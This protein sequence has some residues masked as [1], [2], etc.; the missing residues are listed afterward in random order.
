MTQEQKT[1][2]LKKVK[3]LTPEQEMALAPKLKEALEAEGFVEG[4]LGTKRSIVQDLSQVRV[5]SPRGAKGTKAEGFDNDFGRDN[6]GTVATGSYLDSPNPWG[7]EGTDKPWATED[8]DVTKGMGQELR[9]F[10]RDPTKLSEGQRSFF[11]IETAVLA[12]AQAAEA[13]AA[14]AAIAIK[15]PTTS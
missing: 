14:L 9:V 7:G 3:R 4:E 2:E 1:P 13:Q 15:P 8:A 11:D 12:E 6:W 10:L 5:G